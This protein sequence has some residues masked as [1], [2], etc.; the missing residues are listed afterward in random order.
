MS[1][2]IDWFFEN[3]NEGII[4]EDDCLPADS[5]F[6]FCDQMLKRYRQDTRINLITGTN[7]QNGIIRGEGSYYF[8]DYSNIWGWAS[9]KRTWTNYDPALTNYTADDA[10]A[11]LKNVFSDDFLLAEWLKIFNRLKA[12]E[13]DTWDYQLN[14]VTFFKMG[15]ALHLT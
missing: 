10:A 5:F 8:S 3:E 4:L 9:W 13:I 12:G 11:Q 2:A 1:T 6:Y 15:Y 7:L 14:F